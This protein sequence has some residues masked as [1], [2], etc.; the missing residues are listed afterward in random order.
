[1]FRHRLSPLGLSSFTLYLPNKNGLS[2]LWSSIIDTVSHCFIRLT[3][4]LSILIL[5]ILA[6]QQPN[7][8]FALLQRLSVK[9]ISS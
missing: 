2:V 9:V 5:K 4:I 3:A 6:S 7:V 8:R 1:M